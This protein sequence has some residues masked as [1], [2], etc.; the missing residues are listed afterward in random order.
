MNTTMQGPSGS[1]VQQQH[2][3]QEQQCIAAGRFGEAEEEFLSAGKPK[4]A[5]DM[6]CHQLDWAAALRVAEAG[7]PPSI[8]KICLL[9]VCMHYMCICSTRTTMPSSQ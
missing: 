5:I 4:E 2:P 8:P 3:C 7:D 1:A 6:Y 9:Q